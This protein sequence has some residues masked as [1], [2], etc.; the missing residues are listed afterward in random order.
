MEG[1]S[2]IG[3]MP[4]TGGRGV[5]HSGRGP[6]LSGSFLEGVGVRGSTCKYA[7]WLEFR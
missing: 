3:Q 5:L 4:R 2:R 1:G 6:A 7:V